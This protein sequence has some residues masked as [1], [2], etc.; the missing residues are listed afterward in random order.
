MTYIP[1]HPATKSGGESSSESA[2]RDGFAGLFPGSEGGMK[3]E[4]N[5]L[6]GWGIFRESYV[7]GEA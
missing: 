1:C 5:G 7:S 2:V 6:R 3:L 4:K